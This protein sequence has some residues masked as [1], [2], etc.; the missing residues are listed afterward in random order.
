ME[1][2]IKR[3]LEELGEDPNREGLVRTPARVKESLGFLTEGYRQ[4]PV[5]LIKDSVYSDRHE[6]L[7]TSA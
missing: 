5:K 4:D 3:L 1:E 7:G 2:L 6:E